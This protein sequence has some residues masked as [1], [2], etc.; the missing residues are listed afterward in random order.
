MVAIARARLGQS[1]ESGTLLNM[2]IAGAQVLGLSSVLCYL[3]E[4][5]SRKLNSKHSSQDSDIQ[6]GTLTGVLAPEAAA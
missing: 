3:P 5:L 1:Q 2:G 4:H 6:T